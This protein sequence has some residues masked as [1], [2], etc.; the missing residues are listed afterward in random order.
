MVANFFKKIISASHRPTTYQTGLLQAKAY[1]ILKQNTNSILSSQHE[2][3]STGWA[4]LGFL[5]DNPDGVRLS[6]CANELGVEGAFI[7][8]L[9]GSLKKKGLIAYETAPDDARV[10][11]ATLTPLGKKFV[12]ETEKVVRDQMKKLVKDVSIRD[13]MGYLK[14]LQA[15]VKNNKGLEALDNSES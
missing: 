1:R 5:Y 11:R 3:T 10:K 8:P 9:A 7:T 15:I 12:A 14:V 6:D 13:L 2:I 4:F